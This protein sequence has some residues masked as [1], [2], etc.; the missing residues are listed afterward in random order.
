MEPTR[1]CGKSP[2]DLPAETL[3]TLAEIGQELNASLELDKVLEKT[4]ELVKRLIDYEIFSVMLIDE[5]SGRLFHRFAIG[6]TRTLSKR[7]EFPIGQGIT[8]TAAATGLAVRVGDVSQDSRYLNAFDAVQSELAVP[9]VYKG[10][11][12]G[13]LDIQSRQ[14]NYFTK[15]QQNILTLL[16]SRLA[17]AIENARLFQ[18]ARVDRRKRCWC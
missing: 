5:E 14:L 7:G 4:A 17:V 18:R 6:Y 12:I 3:A 8:G 1:T 9:L 11:A 2:F 13:V 10:K 15:D 16:A